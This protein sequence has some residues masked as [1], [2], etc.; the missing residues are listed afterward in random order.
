VNEDTGPIISLR[1]V[2]K[3]YRRGEIEL[4][5]LSGIDLD[6]AP[7]SFEALMGP[8]GS[9]KS[10]L[11][12]LI[13]GLDRPSGGVVTVAGTDLAS[14]T[15][16]ELADWRAA[17]VGFVFQLYNLLPVL[18]AAENVELPLLLAP[19]RPDERRE[20]VRAALE[21]VGI[22]HRADHRPAQLSGGEQQ[23]VAIARA[24]VTDPAVIVADEPTGD[25]DRAAAA[26]VLDLMHGLHADLLKTIVMVTH[27]PAAAARADRIR[28]LEK[29]ALL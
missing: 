23:R 24:I 22:A 11:L 2:S 13:S 8:S 4:P 16:P 6:I 1:H 26:Q 5:V 27:D 9:G 18:T 21:A 20:H 7:G 28:H 3:I 25:L 19:L 17:N 10:T 14:L 12:N 15:E 29:G